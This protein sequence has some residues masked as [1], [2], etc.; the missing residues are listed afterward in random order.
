MLLV[1]ANTKQLSLSTIT[2]LHYLYLDLFFS[3]LY[4]LKKDN[5]TCFCSE[6]LNLEKKPQATKTTYVLINKNLSPCYNLLCYHV[7]SVSHVKYTA[8]S[9]AKNVNTEF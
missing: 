9:V 6:L 8:K 3:T 1:F 2:S 7:L 4:S 5:S